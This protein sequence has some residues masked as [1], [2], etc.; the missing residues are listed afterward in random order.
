MPYVLPPDPNRDP[1]EAEV[2]AI[3]AQNGRVAPPENGRFLAPGQLSKKAKAAGHAS[4]P[5]SSPPR[6]SREALEADMLGAE[7]PPAVLPS[8]PPSESEEMRSRHRD[9]WRAKKQPLAEEIAPPSA[10]PELAVSPFS[11]QIRAPEPSA[12]SGACPDAVF[13]RLQQR[14]ILL[15]C[16]LQGPHPNQPHMH[17]LAPV[18]DG[19]I[20]FIGWW[21]Q[22]E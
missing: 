15:E 17:N 8:E 21:H 1:V 2:R 12:L 13:L 3:Q 16:T 19:D 20:V 10:D 14:R 7:L 4:P 9:E 18:E 6:A 11:P 5:L 22:G